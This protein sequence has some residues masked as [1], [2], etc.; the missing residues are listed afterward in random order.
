M[1]FNHAFR[2]S[3]LPVPVQGAL[4]LTAA[5]STAALTAGQL[6]VFDAKTFQN[7][8]GAPQITPFIIAQGSY[9]TSDKIGGNRFLG[10]YQESVKSKA[11]NPRY[12]TRVIKVNSASPVN[13]I[14][15]ICVCNMECGKTYRLRVDLKGSPA[16][17]LL[18]HNLY[19]TLDAFTGC[20]TDDCSATCTGA[21]YY[22]YY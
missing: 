10:G 14:K 2:K 21:F 4:T 1:Y 5:S 22:C 18:S 8:S 13:Q 7:A 9:F 6:G 11:I 12:I 20:C 17:R 16:L 15:D 3:F 19:K